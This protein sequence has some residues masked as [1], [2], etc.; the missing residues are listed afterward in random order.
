MVA[1]KNSSELT[2]HHHILYQTKLGSRDVEGLCSKLVFNTTK[3]KVYPVSVI[4]R[5]SERELY[6]VRDSD[7][8]QFCHCHLVALRIT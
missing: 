2:K 1:V 7:S 6:T 5:L 3:S 8:A 4:G